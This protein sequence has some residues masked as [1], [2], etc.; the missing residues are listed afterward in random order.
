MN[1]KPGGFV[2]HK[3]K[4]VLVHDFKRHVLRL[5]LQTFRGRDGNGDGASHSGFAGRFY[6]PR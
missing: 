5:D 1:H 6:F 3:Q 2:D 4:F